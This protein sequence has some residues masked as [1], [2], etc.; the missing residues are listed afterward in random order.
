MTLGL[1]RYRRGDSAAAT[2][3]LEESLS[4]CRA[5]GEQFRTIGALR[6]LGCLARERGDVSRARALLGESLEMAHGLA[7][8]G[9]DRL[10]VARSLE[11]FAVLAAAWGKAEDAVRLEAVALDLYR[12]IGSPPHPSPLIGRERW[13]KPA[14]EALGPER[15]AAAQAEGRALSLDQAIA[16]AL[17]LEVADRSGATLSAPA[18][19]ATVGIPLT[20]RERE[21][22]DLI[23]QGLSN[24]QIAEQLVIAVSTAERHVANILAKLGF[25]RRTQVA[26]W[27]AQYAAKLEPGGS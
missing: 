24:R 25:A 17:K 10:L 20:A 12:R 21:I 15:A 6:L 9:G 11:A 14:H 23:A 1:I 16:Q 27:A 8:T 2:S 4:Q 22:A 7:K 19:A 5:I 13:L 3:F 18:G 26:V